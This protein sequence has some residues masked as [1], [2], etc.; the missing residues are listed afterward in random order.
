MEDSGV[1]KIVSVKFAKEKEREVEGGGLIADIIPSFI[2]CL[3]EE[4][5]R[6]M[7]SSAGSVRLRKEDIP[8]LTV[9]LAGRISVQSHIFQHLPKAFCD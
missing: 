2:L 7:I 1:S 3:I 8:K 4:F 9:L 6:G 5:I